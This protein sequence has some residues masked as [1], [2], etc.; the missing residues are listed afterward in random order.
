MMKMR[1]LRGSN[2]ASI[3]RCIFLLR[4]V[5]IAA[6]DDVLQDLIPLQSDVRPSDGAEIFFENFVIFVS[7]AS[8]KLLK[9]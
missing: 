4:F 3:A 9:S 7:V 6:S 2:F 8:A 5:D 1:M